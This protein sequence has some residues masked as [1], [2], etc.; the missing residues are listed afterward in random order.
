MRIKVITL[1][2][3]PVFVVFEWNTKKD[4]VNNNKNVV[5]NKQEPVRKWKEE[6]FCKPKKQ[7]F[8]PEP[9]KTTEKVKVPEKEPSFTM[10]KTQLDEYIENKM[11]KKG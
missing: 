2:V 7:V 4:M 5:D 9:L 3:L 1:L 10:T 8:E 6:D 11:K